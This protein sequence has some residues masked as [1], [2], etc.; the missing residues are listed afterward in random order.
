M[1][2][3]QNGKSK[4]PAPRIKTEDLEDSDLTESEGSLP[5]VPS[6]SPDVS[7]TPSM[8]NRP[9][10][11]NKEPQYGEI[12]PYKPGYIWESRRAL[13]DAGMHLPLQAGIHGRQNTGAYSIVLSG[14]YEDDIDDGYELS[15]QEDQHW[16]LGNKALQMSQ[17]HKRPVRVIRGSKLRSKWAPEE[18]YRYDGLYDV[19]ESSTARG[20]SG[21][22]V[23]LFRFRRRPDQSPIPE[24]PNN[25]PI[26]APR[27]PERLGPAPNPN[28]TTSRPRA[29]SSTAEKGKQPEFVEGSS[30]GRKSAPKSSKSSKSAARP[31]SSINSIYANYPQLRRAAEA[32]RAAQE[33]KAAAEAAAVAA[34]T[35]VK[36]EE[37]TSVG[38]GPD[39]SSGTVEGVM[40]R[41]EEV[42]S[43][44]RKAT[45]APLPMGGDDGGISLAPSLTRPPLG[46]A[47]FGHV[48]TSVSDMLTI[49]NQPSRPAL[50][51]PVIKDEEDEVRDEIMDYSDD[52]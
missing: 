17:V 26:V 20:K 15:Q 25:E 22:L 45:S 9:K 38:P 3:R 12:R 11:K 39:L 31:S 30:K 36:V 37:P 29:R 46:A 47:A 44:S 27:M 52:D 48:N 1:S 10:K 49:D 19:V 35:Q 13:H 40:W 2:D 7:E 33:A 42:S 6:P 8:P 16:S 5:N 24:N 43:A 4:L 34:S 32:A 41:R 14:G 23:C 21:H 18:G 50:R 28:S 51:S